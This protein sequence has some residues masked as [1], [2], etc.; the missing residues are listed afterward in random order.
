MAAQKAGVGGR[1]EERGSDRLRFIQSIALIYRHAQEPT[2]SRPPIAACLPGQHCGRN[3]GQGMSSK[4]QEGTVDTS[5]LHNAHLH[6][7]VAAAA[8]AAI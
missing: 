4:W 2:K 5:T 1:Q 3:K 8:A 7:F 6:L